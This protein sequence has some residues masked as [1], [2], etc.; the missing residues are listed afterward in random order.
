MDI[1]S[2]NRASGGAF[3]WFLAILSSLAILCHSTPFLLAVLPHSLVS[4]GYSAPIRQNRRCH[5]SWEFFSPGTWWSPKSCG[6]VWS[7]LLPVKWALSMN[8]YLVG[9]FNPLKNMKVNWDDYSQYM[10]NKKC[11]KPP[12]SYWL[13]SLTIN[14]VWCGENHEMIWNDLR[15]RCPKSWDYSQWSSQSSDHWGI[16]TT[17]VTPIPHDL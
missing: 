14:S 7:S 9:G 13:H 16:E 17:M 5:H 11:S 3:L 15:W 1:F 12:T 10:G 6:C 4:W 2:S 8:S